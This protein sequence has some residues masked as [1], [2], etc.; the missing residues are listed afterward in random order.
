MRVWYTSHKKGFGEFFPDKQ[1]R[2]VRGS[3]AVARGRRFDG[4]MARFNVPLFLCLLLIFCPLR[5]GLF[6]AAYLE[7]VIDVLP[8]RIS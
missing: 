8:A 7:T 1:N 5:S 2:R 4:I 3:L 6:F